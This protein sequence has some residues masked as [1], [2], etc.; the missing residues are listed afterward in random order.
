MVIVALEFN[1]PTKG[2]AHNKT[3]RLNPLMDTL[4]PQSDGPL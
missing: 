4:K 3:V 2:Y 1:V